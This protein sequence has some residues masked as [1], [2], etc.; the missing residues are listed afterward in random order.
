NRGAR[1]DALASAAPERPRVMPTLRRM[2]VAAALLAAPVAALTADTPNQRGP[3]AWKKIVV[4]KVFRSEGA[5]VADVNR[6]GKMDILIGDFWYEAPDWKMHPIR[7]TKEY[8]E[9]DRAKGY[10][11]NGLASYSECMCCW[12]DDVNGD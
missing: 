3:L 2:I 7:R 8:S 5:A 4:D 10:Y 1:T 9:S 6:D 11:G 12:A